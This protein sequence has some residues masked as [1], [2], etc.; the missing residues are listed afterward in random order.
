[1]FKKLRESLASIGQRLKRTKKPF[2]APEIVEAKMPEP[3]PQEVRPAPEIKTTEL[4][5]ASE[6]L[7]AALAQCGITAEQ[8]A[9]T[10]AAVG[11]VI[12]KAMENV[13]PVVT[14]AVNALWDALPEWYR[15]AIIHEAELQSVATPKQWHLYKYGTWKQRKKWANALLKKL[16]K[17]K[18][19]KGGTQ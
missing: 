19:R 8:F 16:K 2:E 7:N 12:R 5:E 10:C 9:D 13:V 1:M 11:E 3:T 17:E 14:K 6:R 18:K 4:S 15:E